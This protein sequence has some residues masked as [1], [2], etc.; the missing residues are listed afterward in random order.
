MR[1]CFL[2]NELSFKHGWGRYSIG[3]IKALTLKGYQPL[4]L[5]DKTSQ[6]NDLKEVKSYKLSIFSHLS[7]ILSSAYYLLLTLQPLP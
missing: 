5:L 3:L 7:L 1:I 2:T 6:E 4:I